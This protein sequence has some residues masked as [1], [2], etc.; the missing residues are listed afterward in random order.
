MRD[1]TTMSFY[2]LLEYG[3]IV[4]MSELPNSTKGVIFDQIEERKELL[5]VGSLVEFS[6]IKD[7]DSDYV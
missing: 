4:S 7:G 3:Q 6:E 1:I 5:Q 2:E